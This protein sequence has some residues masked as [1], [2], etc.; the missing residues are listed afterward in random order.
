MVQNIWFHL[1]LTAQLLP[2]T[3]SGWSMPSSP[4][5][6]PANHTRKAYNTHSYRKKLFFSDQPTYKTKS[7]VVYVTN[8]V[9][10]LAT[11]LMKPSKS[12][13][14]VC[15]EISKSWR[16]WFGT[17]IRPLNHSWTMCIQYVNQQTSK[18]AL[19]AGYFIMHLKK[20]TT[21]LY[22]RKKRAKKHCNYISLTPTPSFTCLLLVNATKEQIW[23]WFNH[24]HVYTIWR[25][26]PL[27]LI[28]YAIAIDW[29][30]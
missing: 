7:W 13:A 17:I 18:I 3:S 14:E 20:N 28:T 22:G 19:E 8:D 25:F 23:N 11:H 10:R 9:Q 5:L 24:I 29:T 30:H 1:K 12:P 4:C 26:L 27:P 16:R 21:E 15:S 6:F 2:P